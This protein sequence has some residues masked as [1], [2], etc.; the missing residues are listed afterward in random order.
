MIP[1]SLFRPRVSLND[2]VVMR[3]SP[4]T[5]HYQGRVGFFF[6]S[7]KRFSLFFFSISGRFFLHRPNVLFS[8]VVSSASIGVSHS[9]HLCC[10]SYF[11]FLRLFH[12]SCSPAILTGPQFSFSSQIGFP[13]HDCYD[14]SP[15]SRGVLQTPVASFCLTPLN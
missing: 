14:P 11:P 6:S 8:V 3:T 2:D 7:Y 5:L 9:N 4:T 15:F 13:L 12:S 1:P 10:L